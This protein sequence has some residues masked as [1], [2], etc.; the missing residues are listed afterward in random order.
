MSVTRLQRGLFGRRTAAVALLLAVEVAGCTSRGQVVGPAVVEKPG[1]PAGA[2]SCT[3]SAVPEGAEVLYRPELAGCA[4][5][6]RKPDSMPDAPMDSAEVRRRFDW[7]RTIPHV[8]ELRIL[9]RHIP[10]PAGGLPELR[11]LDLNSNASRDLRALEQLQRL[12]HLEVRV[13]DD[14]CPDLATIAGLSQLRELAV[15]IATCKSLAPLGRLERLARLNLSHVTTHDLGVLRGMPRLREL[16]LAY[17]DLVDRRIE[18]P[19]LI[20][21]KIS[22][23]DKHDRPLDLADIPGLH[24][25]ESLELTGAGAVKNPHL[26]G[27]C[28]RLRR[29]TV[30]YYDAPELLDYAYHLPALEYLDVSP[31]VEIGANQAPMGGIWNLPAL[32]HLVIQESVLFVIEDWLC[33]DHGL[34]RLELVREGPPRETRDLDA[35]RACRP[36]LELVIQ[37]LP[38]RRGRQVS[39]AAARGLSGR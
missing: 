22:V 20:G 26:L 32:R 7:I 2:S 35:V 28:S 1:A 15:T 8:R 24:A 3:S 12:E 38:D 9:S 33:K 10:L 5:I 17:S 37:E 30:Q 13:Y 31:S 36:D 21:L 6:L 18:A 39:R 29:L 27:D 16:E 11:R 25:L 34:E 23:V 19:G 14:G 4:V